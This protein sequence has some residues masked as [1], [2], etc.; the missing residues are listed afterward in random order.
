MKTFS[1]STEETN[2]LIGRERALDYIADLIKRDI[3]MYIY[4]DIVPRLGLPKDGKYTL[5]QD[6]KTLE[7]TE[8]EPK[9][10]TK[11]GK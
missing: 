11:G 1:L 5:S 4:M 8:E 7:V 6:R 10:I 2:N 9:I 3:N